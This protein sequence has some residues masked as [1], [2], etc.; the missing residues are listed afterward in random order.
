MEN[1]RLL[2]VVDGYGGGARIIVLVLSSAL[3]CMR[4]SFISFMMT[5]CIFLALRLREHG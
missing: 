2:S 5:Y 4:F 3:L 1:L